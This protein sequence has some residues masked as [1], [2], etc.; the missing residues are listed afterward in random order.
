MTT[1]FCGTDLTSVV[2]GTGMLH[3]VQTVP[4]FN[5]GQDCSI[6]CITTGDRDVDFES[7]HF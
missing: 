5:Y 3:V 2:C 1:I 7:V 6:L 4:K